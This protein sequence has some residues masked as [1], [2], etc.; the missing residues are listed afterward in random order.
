MPIFFTTKVRVIKRRTTATVAIVGK[1]IRTLRSSCD[2]LSSGLEEILLED[3]APR[4]ATCSDEDGVQI[5]CLETSRETLDI[6][7]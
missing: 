7:L 4:A 2:R 3:I 1:I 6:L 5:D